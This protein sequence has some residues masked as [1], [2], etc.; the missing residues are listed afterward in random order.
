M[1]YDNFIALISSWKNLIEHEPPF[2]LL[3]QN[4][5]LLLFETEEA[6]RQFI[7]GHLQK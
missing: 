7:V 2:A 5:H 6:M 4:E 3:Y 1:T